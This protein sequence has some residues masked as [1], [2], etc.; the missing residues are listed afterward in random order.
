ML[1]FKSPRSSICFS[2]T[3]LW[4]MELEGSVDCSVRVVLCQ[5]SPSVGHID[6]IINRGAQKRHSN[7]YKEERKGGRGNWLNAGLW[8]SL[9][10]KL[11]RRQPPLHVQP[12]PFSVRENT[13]CQFPWRQTHCFMAAL[14]SILSNDTCSLTFCQIRGL[15]GRVYLSQQQR[16]LHSYSQ[17]SGTNGKEKSPV[18]YVC[19]I[20]F[21]WMCI[22]PHVMP[23]WTH[24]NCRHWVTLK[25]WTLFFPLYV[26]CTRA[27]V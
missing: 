11:L 26:Q 22:V 27:H 15:F 25:P 14:K 6:R 4:A 17:C 18:N 24:L 8:S 3:F 20:S 16:P 2:F 9:H 21:L 13:V 10:I 1:K 5:K 12:T 7:K 23:D 19:A